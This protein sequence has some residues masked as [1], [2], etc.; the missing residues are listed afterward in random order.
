MSVSPI[1]HILLIVLLIG[2][3][4]W[5][6]RARRNAIDLKREHVFLKE[7]YGEFKSDTRKL[8]H[9][10]EEGQARTEASLQLIIAMLTKNHH[11]K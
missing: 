6:F 4:I 7:S 11:E 5:H 2:S 10:L 3:Y 1:L 8:L 9:N